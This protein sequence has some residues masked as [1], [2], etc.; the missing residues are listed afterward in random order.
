M[1]TVD[2]HKDKSGEY[3]YEITVDTPHN[4]TLHMNGVTLSLSEPEAMGLHAGLGSA[5]GLRPEACGQARDPRA[6]QQ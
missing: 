3:I 1:I 4:D 6:T 5:L 2:R